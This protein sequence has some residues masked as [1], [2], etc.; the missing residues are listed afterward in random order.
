M[1]NPLTVLERSGA[2]EASSSE[3]ETRSVGLVSFV[4]LAGWCGLAAGLLEVGAIFA[5]KRLFDPNQL[6]GMSR[7]FIWLIPVTNVLIF[8]VVGVIGCLASWAWPRRGRR[9]FARCLC[10]V[11]VLPMVLAL[12]P[13]VYGPAWLVLVLGAATRAV[14]VIDRHAGLLRRVVRISFPIMAECH[15]CRDGYCRGRTPG[16]LWLLATHEHH[17]G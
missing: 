6:Y 11:T 12:F 13:R 2:G 4:L 16:A 15:P 10:A 8:L 9:I 7:H 14:P 3:R 17:V 1:T 5:R